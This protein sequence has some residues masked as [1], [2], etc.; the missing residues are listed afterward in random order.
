MKNVA[1]F[2]FCKEYYPLVKHFNNLQKNYHLADVIEPLGIGLNNEDI[3]QICNHPPINIKAFDEID[4]SNNAWD[5]L[6]LL[7]S[8]NHLDLDERVFIELAEKAISFGK[9][10]EYIVNEVTELSKD[11]S[12]LDQHYP[13][14]IQ[15]F[16][17][18]NY[19]YE[20]DDLLGSI[21]E[22]RLDI[23]IILIGG[24]VQE[25]DILEI[26]FSLKEQ[27]NKAGKRCS[28]F[29]RTISDYIFGFHNYS[30]ILSQQ[31]KDE[32][33]KID[34]LKYYFQFYSYYDCP[35][36]ILVEAPDALMKYNEMTSNG[37]GILSY[38]LCQAVSFDAIICSVPL[39]LAIPSFIRAV[40]FELER[41]LKTSLAAVHVSN[42]IIDSADMLQ[43]RKVTY[44][45][46]TM[47]RVNK[48]L[49][50]IENTSSIPM[51]NIID[52]SAYKLYEYLC[53]EYMEE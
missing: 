12:M 27:F 25:S 19:V 40:N 51:F 36:I 30:G 52:D 13:N 46:T 14:Q 4:F 37:Y 22:I 29:T 47:E 49:N 3:S 9:K 39:E 33:S 26:L 2:P 6:L 53:Q 5:I 11:F 42:I 10:V 34:E 17:D 24:L 7:N 20:R 32:A 48:H 35:D 18:S 15:I 45:H 21:S 43:S 50:I 8:H 23:P 1:L 38:M 16:V 28:V 31:N 44:T 41:R